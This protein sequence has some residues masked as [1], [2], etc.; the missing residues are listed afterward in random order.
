MSSTEAPAPPPPSLCV[1]RWCGV[2]RGEP[3]PWAESVGRRRVPGGSD[4]VPPAG[5]CVGLLMNPIN[6]VKARATLSSAFLLEVRSGFQLC[7][8]RSWEACVTCLCLSSENPRL[9]KGPLLP[10]FL[11]CRLPGEG[12]T[13]LKLYYR[14]T[15]I[16][17][18]PCQNDRLEM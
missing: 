17:A 9:D 1:S 3:G 12:V 14:E 16:K 7:L 8:V 11:H 5:D 13:V 2:G 4:C 18:T 15:A 6:G 10:V